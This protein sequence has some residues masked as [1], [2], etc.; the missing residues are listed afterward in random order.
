M[1]DVTI[2]DLDAGTPVG[3]AGKAIALNGYV[4]TRTGNAPLGAVS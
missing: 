2:T 4:A 3:T 1:P